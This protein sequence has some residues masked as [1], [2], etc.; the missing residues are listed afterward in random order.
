VRQTKG[1]RGREESEKLTP[2]DINFFA[3]LTFER[4]QIKSGRTFLMASS[5]LHVA[6]STFVRHAFS[7]PII[8]DVFLGLAAPVG[9]LEMSKLWRHYR[10]ASGNA[11]VRIGRCPL[12]SE[13]HES[14]K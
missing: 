2:Q 9:A 7:A 6:R 11:R 1:V 8:L 5:V 13:V 3:L 4:D 12:Y 14:P 10:G